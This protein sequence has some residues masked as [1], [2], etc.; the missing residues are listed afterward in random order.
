MKKKRKEADLKNV[1][2]Q[3]GGLENRIKYSQSDLDNTERRSMKEH[4]EVQT[5]DWFR[6]SF[7]DVIYVIII[8]IW[9]GKMPLRCTSF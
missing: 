9:N 7:F 1:I 4:D 8:C 2:S 3:I 5:W 6:F